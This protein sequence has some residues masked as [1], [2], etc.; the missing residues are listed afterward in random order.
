MRLLLLNQQQLT[1][2]MPTLQEDGAL[3]RRITSLQTE[4]QRRSMRTGSENQTVETL[5]F[6][7]LIQEQV[8]GLT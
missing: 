8:K 5:L 3:E 4:L 6:L 7:L 2:M 1:L